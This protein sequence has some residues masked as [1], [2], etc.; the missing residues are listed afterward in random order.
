M[1]PLQL[2]STSAHITLMILALDWLQ[3]KSLTSKHRAAEPICYFFLR[4]SCLVSILMLQL[5]L[6]KQKHLNFPWLFSAW[7]K[8]QA[9]CALFFAADPSAK[10]TAADL[11]SSYHPRKQ[12]WHNMPTW[13]W[14]NWHQQVS[15][16][17]TLQ[18]QKSR[19][20]EVLETPKQKQRYTIEFREYMMLYSH[21][22]S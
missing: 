21:G 1:G 8:A 9:P 13:P 6:R 18:N 7:M 15:L 17:T 20:L 4:K 19:S 14:R 16:K 12:I 5:F 11:L 3:F 10:H 22:N 2:W